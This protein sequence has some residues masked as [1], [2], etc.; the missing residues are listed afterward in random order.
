MP[1]NTWI[2]SSS[3]S[4]EILLLAK[5][6]LA[7]HKFISRFW[8]NYL[9]MLKLSKRNFF[10]RNYV[11]PQRSYEN[12]FFLAFYLIKILTCILC[13]LYF[14]EINL[15]SLISDWVLQPTHGER[16]QKFENY[17][18]KSCLPVNV[19]QLSNFSKKYR[20]LT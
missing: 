6:F 2:T 11:W 17:T 1:V 9:W 3:T 4:H 16:N 10:S 20:I 7:A 19:K 5:F 8:W 14:I 13:C 18:I 12:T 15:R